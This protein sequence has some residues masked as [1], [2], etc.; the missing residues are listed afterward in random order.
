MEWNRRLHDFGCEWN[1]MEQQLSHQIVNVRVG[2]VIKQKLLCELHD[3]DLMTSDVNGMERH[4]R[5]HEFGCEW[6]GTNN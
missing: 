2:Y 4:R 3:N 6:N 1:G 5:I